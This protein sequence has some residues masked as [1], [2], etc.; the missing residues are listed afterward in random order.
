[1]MWRSYGDAPAPILST[2]V[3][4]P[5]APDTVLEML[6]QGKHTLAEILPEVGLEYPALAFSQT[7]R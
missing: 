1:M 3:N 2:T 7:A 6:S 5:A 4:Q